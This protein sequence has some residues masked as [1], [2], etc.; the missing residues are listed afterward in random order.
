MSDLRSLF[1]LLPSRALAEI[2]VVKQAAEPHAVEQVRAEAL[3]FLQSSRKS[4]R[5]LRGQQF[6]L[7]E[8]YTYTHCFFHTHF[9][10][11][12][13]VALGAFVRAVQ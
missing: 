3:Q 5:R 11:Y 12:N 10:C 4:W 8:I 2:M 7:F 13:I 9:P 1:F 6:K